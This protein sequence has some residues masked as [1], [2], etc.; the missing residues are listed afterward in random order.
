MWG[1]TSPR[2]QTG[3]GQVHWFG[4]GPGGSQQGN[5]PGQEC[6]ASRMKY[7]RQLECKGLMAPGRD[8][9][10]AEVKGYWFRLAWDRISPASELLFSASP[11]LPHDGF[12]EKGGEKNPEA[13]SL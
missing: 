9:W 8:R 12:A 10:H 2:M 7:W 6:Y 1:Y 4:N 5:I 13:C 3:M 11:S